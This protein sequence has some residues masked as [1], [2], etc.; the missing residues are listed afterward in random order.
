MGHAL[1]P[2]GQFDEC[3]VGHKLGHGALDGISLGNCLHECFPLFL[4]LLI[5]Q[6]PAGNHNIA[7]AFLVPG[8]QKMM[9]LS[10]VVFRGFHVPD[11]HLAHRAE[12]PLSQDIQGESPLDGTG[13]LPFHRGP[14][15]PGILKHGCHSG[16]GNG[17]GE[18]D[19]AFAE[20]NH[21]KLDRIA[22]GIGEFS[23]VIQKF[24]PVHHPVALCARINIYSAFP[25]GNDPAFHHVPLFEFTAHLCIV[26]LKQLLKTH[27]FGA[28]AI[29]VFK[30]FVHFPSP[31]PGGIRKYLNSVELTIRS[32]YR[33]KA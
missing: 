14:A 2:R 18:D 30:F 3:S 32:G 16:P 29:F 26:G 25:N 20:G 7:P 15:P 8:N 12:G 4:D 27:L 22:F 24:A 31:G 33:C 28:K 1:H 17:L 5:E 23:V 21:V 10:H 9:G 6:F 11:I 13:D 19:F